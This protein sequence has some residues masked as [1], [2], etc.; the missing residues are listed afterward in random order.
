ME[1]GDTLSR[2]P[3]KICP[4]KRLGTHHDPRLHVHTPHTQRFPADTRTHELRGTCAR[5][6]PK[7]R[8]GHKWHPV[9]KDI[10]DGLVQHYG[11]SSA[12][13]LELPVLC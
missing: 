9:A 13:A 8:N 2:F 7:P 1:N 6:T 4:C 3:E 12:L 11:N 10:I 5:D